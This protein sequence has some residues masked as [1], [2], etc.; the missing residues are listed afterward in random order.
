[1]SSTNYDTS[2]I[3][4]LEISISDFFDKSKFTK[5]KRFMNAQFYKLVALQYY[6]AYDIRIDNMYIS[7]I[8]KN[9]EPIGYYVVKC[10]NNTFTYECGLL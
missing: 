2:N 10:E 7:T 3:Q 1:M 5:V 8:F 4:L 6:I 9:R